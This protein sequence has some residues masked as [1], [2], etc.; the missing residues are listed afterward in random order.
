MSILLTYFGAIIAPFFQ[1]LF[2]NQGN[3]ISGAK[4][5]FPDGK[6]LTG[7]WFIDSKNL[8]EAIQSFFGLDAIGRALGMMLLGVVLYRLYILQGKKDKL[9]YRKLVYIFLPIGLILTSINIFWLSLENYDPSIAVAV[10][11]THLTLPT[12]YSV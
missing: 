12:I 9:F 3:L 1:V 5:S 2:D 6:G 4:E 7:Y 11:Y 10:S 8:G